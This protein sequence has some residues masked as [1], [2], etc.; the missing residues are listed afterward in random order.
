MQLAGTATT[1]LHGQTLAVAVAMLRF[2][3]SWK[4]QCSTASYSKH[5]FITAP[6]STR[7]FLSVDGSDMSLAQGGFSLSVPYCGWAWGDPCP[8]GAVW[9]KRDL[10]GECTLAP[11]GRT[12]VRVL[13]ARAQ[14]AAGWKWWW[15]PAKRHCRTFWNDEDKD[16]VSWSSSRHCTL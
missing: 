15:L 16:L 8:W 11:T 6:P 5:H 14:L 13:G 3:S 4:P 9:Q 2:P 1:C 7:C 10:A 12:I